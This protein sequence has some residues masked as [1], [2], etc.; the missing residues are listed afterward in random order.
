MP[1]T[2]GGR[3]SNLILLWY[4]VGLCSNVRQMHWYYEAGIANTLFPRCYNI[5]QPDQLHAFID[6]YRHVKL[7]WL[8]DNGLFRIDHDAKSC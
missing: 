7:L 1:N 5:S 3:V 6:D 4:K 2:R 8:W